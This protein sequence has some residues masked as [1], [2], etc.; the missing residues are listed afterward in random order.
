MADS[1][2]NSSQNPVNFEGQT[3]QA[4]QDFQGFAGGPCILPNGNA[5]EVGIATIEIAK[6]PAGDALDVLVL[7]GQNYFFTFEEG[8]VQSFEQ[9]GDDLVLSFEDGSFI[10]LRNFANATIGDDPAQVAF[11]Q[12]LDGAQFA[13]FDPV[14]E[15]VPAQ[16]ELEEPQVEIRESVSVSEAVESVNDIVNAQ[17]DTPT[18][19]NAIEA[20]AGETPRETAQQLA[21]IEPA[22]GDAGAAGAGADAGG[23][24]FQSSFAPQGVDPLQDVGPI[25]PTALQ[26]GL[27]NV[28]NN[29]LILQANGT[30]GLLSPAPLSVD[31]TDL[32]PN[33][34]SGTVV[35]DFGADGPGTIAPEG[36]F[37]VSGSVAG[38][39]LSSGGEAVAIAASVDGYVGTI[40]GG[41]TN[42]FT[43]VIDPNTGNYTFT[44]NLPF[45][46]A[47]GADPD[48]VITI[49][50]DVVARDNDGDEAF[51]IVRINVLDDAPVLDDS[52]D[53][54]S[55]EDIVD[56]VNG[57]LNADFGADGAGTVVPNGVTSFDGVAT[58]TSGGEVIAIAATAD[59][60]VGTINAGATNIFT[61]TIDSSTGDYEFTLNGPID[62]TN[63]ADTVTLNFG[64][65]ITDFDGDSDVGTISIIVNDGSPDIDDVN[66]QPGFG[67][68]DF[69]EADLEN[70]SLIED[71]ILDVDFGA[72]APGTILPAD[73]YNPSVPLFSNGEAVTV[74]STADGYVGT[75]NGGAINVFSLTLQSPTGYYVFTQN[76]SLDH[77][78]SSN[79]NDNIIIEFTFT[80]TDSDGDT[81]DGNIVIQITDDGPIAIDDTASVAD[82]GTVTGNVITSN[83]EVSED[84]PSVITDVDG[85]APGT[86]ITGTYGTLTLNADGSYSY[87]ASGNTGG[88]IDTFT[89]TL[90]DFDGDSDTAELVI[91]VA[92]DIPVIGNVDNLVTD[93]TDLNPTDSDSGTITA[94]FGNDGPGTFAFNGTN[95]ASTALR[96]N[97]DAVDVALING[98]Y[99]GTAN[100]QTI[101]TLTLN[102]TTGT[103]DF[104]LQGVLDHPNTNNPNDAIRLQFGVDAIDADGDRTSDTIQVTVRDDGPV[105][106]DDTDSVDD[107]GTTT[108]NVITSN[109]EVSFDART[110]VS[111]VNGQV[112]TPGQLNTITGT[113]GTLT[114]NAN[115]FYRYTANANNP[116]GD[117]TFTYT[118]TDF[119]GDSDTAELVIKVDADYIPDNLQ[120]QNLVVDETDLNPTD[121]DS[122]TITADFGNDDPGTF[123]L[124]TTH[125]AS[126]SLTS[127]GQAVDVALVNG[128]YVGTA[129]GQTIFTLTLNENTGAYDFTLEGTLDHP[130]GNNANDPIRLNFGV[131]AIDADGDRTSD[132]IQVTV[133]DDGPI[134]SDRSVLIDETGLQTSNEVSITKTLTHDYGADGRGTIRPSGDFEMLEVVGGTPQPLTSGGQP[135]V[136]SQTSNGYE[137]TVNGQSVF[138]LVVNNNGRYTYTQR[139]P[140]DHPDTNSADEAIWLKFGVVITDADG[141]T[142]TANIIIDVLDDAP[143]AVNDSNSLTEDES[144]ASGNILG[145]DDSGADGGLQLLTTGT[146]TSA[147]GRVEINANGTYTYT[148]TSDA[149]GTSTF[150]YTIRDADGDTDTARLRITQAEFDAG[151]PDARNDLRDNVD[152]NI[153]GNVITGQNNDN[154]NGSDILSPD[155]GNRIS[156]VDGVNIPNGGSRTIN[157]KYGVLTISSDGTYTYNPNSDVVGTDDFIYT[158][159]DVD[160]DTDTARLRIKV[161]TDI[162]HVPDAKNDRRDVTSD[163][164]ITGNVIT[165]ENNDNT[166]G[167]D[168]LSLDGGNRISAVDGVNIPNGGSRTING[169]YGVLTISSDGTYTYNP[170]SDVVGTDDFIYTL[171]DVDGDTDTA[172]LRINVDTD[173]DHVPDAEDDRANAGNQTGPL[174]YEGNLL[175]NDDFGGDGPGSPKIVNGTGT[176]DLDYDARLVISSDGDWVLTLPSSV[177]AN[178]VKD[179]SFNY[180]IQDADGD[181]STAKLTFT[182]TPLA[183]D[184]DGDGLEVTSVQ[185]GVVFDYD[186]DGEGE[187]TSWVGSDDG[188]LVQDRNGDGQIN[189]RSE[190]FG[191]MFGHADGFSHLSELDSNQDGQITA[192]DEQWSELKVWRDLDQD[193]ETDEGELF[194]L[195][196]LD[197]ESIDLDANTTNETLE[198]DT[199]VSHE[200]T[201]TTGDGETHG[202][203][204]VHLAYD[205]ILY[206]STDANAPAA[207]TFTIEQHRGNHQIVDFK[208]S[209]G[210]A[211]DLSQVISGYDATQDAINDFVFTVNN[212]GNTEV[213]VDNTGSGNINLA[214][215]VATLDGVTTNINELSENGSIII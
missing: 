143:N 99:V 107:G 55:E 94:N 90:T 180:T 31:E 14:V 173:I 16:E 83:D 95:S 156:A 196:A 182:I 82:A 132:T 187:Q 189:D 47:D 113:Y 96:S 56:S 151:A 3:A 48:D 42:V 61:V 89:Y 178:F 12:I 208:A 64:A 8:A 133:R 202:I 198:G 36:T 172:R 71:G 49:D 25:G 206:G 154:T 142:D 157:G 102:E 103:Y 194:G 185:E 91:T 171:R 165:G 119:D 191:D 35:V 4:G 77:P 167:A 78:D 123:A 22:A 46:H 45:D 69:F 51:T 134:I 72:D 215:Q 28:N 2:D 57:S 214:H 147:F 193:G 192:D 30:P 150:N 148:R 203:Y 97:G 81:D 116:G 121:S 144:T 136:V 160:G 33:V 6:P 24:G 205:E 75:I 127:D 23:F 158:L 129:N 98:D 183:L 170:N 162:D 111:E 124:N 115:G 168:T 117:D 211:L 19:L 209:E 163:D 164:D 166:G 58:L 68:E 141:D 39:G 105:A 177:P 76:L 190:M 197:I 26:F 204:D 7:P 152:N 37:N 44:Q 73:R 52:T 138:E 85:V 80:A 118:L 128:E 1:N 109:D 195:E 59:G 21:R 15:T 175:T 201:F 145:N 146:F 67:F 174:R 41:A 200:S 100:G 79:P 176:F 110:L 199:W 149:A 62:H 9:Q 87:T 169:K 40:N 161:D 74:T 181:R 34:V 17:V 54:V 135:V 101:F 32:G 5:A 184:L 18:A 66:P 131:D 88:G 38:G 63:G 126:T 137:G 112:I 186:N 53:S 108:G 27:P 120:V 50:F 65:V 92:D 43:L 86:P 10:N 213:Y 11:S 130:N 159:R 70:G 122:G 93:E 20:A 104:V 155:G 139:A 188:F 153:T 179:Y 212:N 106:R 114:I 140:L 84:S 13:S 29:N 60:Y 210:D 125:S 207:D